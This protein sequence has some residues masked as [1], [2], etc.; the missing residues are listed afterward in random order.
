MIT[1]EDDKRLAAAI[2]AERRATR[3]KL[4]LQSFG[5]QLEAWA[6]FLA[7]IIPIA[8]ALG[9]GYASTPG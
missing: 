1:D 2:R 9:L 3:P 8:I 4:M 5:R 7:A 6:Q